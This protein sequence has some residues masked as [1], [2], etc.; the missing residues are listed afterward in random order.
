MSGDLACEQQVGIVPQETTLF[1][2]SV[3]ENI[4]YGKL[5]RDPDRI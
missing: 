2:D 5:E 4:R 3:A 1:S